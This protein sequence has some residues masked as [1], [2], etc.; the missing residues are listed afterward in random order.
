MNSSALAI[1]ATSIIRARGIA[2]SESAMFSWMVRL[3]SR[4]S[5]STTPMCR[6]SQ[7]GS[8]WARSIP[9]IST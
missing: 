2:G 6:R 5:C 7:A 3:N 9:S 1:R 8:T 4:F